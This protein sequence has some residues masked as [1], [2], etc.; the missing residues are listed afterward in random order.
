MSGDMKLQTM[1][2]VAFGSAGETY[3][4]AL[5]GSI[6]VW[7][8]H[9][10]VRAVKA[11]TGPVFSMHTVMSGGTVQK[12]LS[13]GKDGVV[14]VWDGDLRKH[15]ALP[16]VGSPVRAIS[17]TPKM[18]SILIGTKSNNIFELGKDKPRLLLD[19]HTNG[20][21]WGLGIHPSKPLFATGSDDNTIRLWDNASCSLLKQTET[22]YPCRSVAFSA[23]GQ[24]LAAGLVNGHIL[25]LDANTLVTLGGI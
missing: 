20:A 25:I 13:G 3:T 11:H 10:A 9:Q 2:S 21:L 24:L 22:E 6:Y 4:G 12:V 19:G 5:D 16:S 1:L 7:K 15:R 23:D 18:D 14:K 8:G 17:C